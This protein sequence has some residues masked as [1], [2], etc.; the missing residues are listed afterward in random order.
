MRSRIVIL[1][2]ICSACG[3]AAT[4]QLSSWRPWY[5]V[6]GDQA[7]APQPGQ[8]IRIT[9]EGVTE[10]L[11]GDE[12]LFREQLQSRLADLLARRGYMLVSSGGEWD[13][14]LLYRTSAQAALMMNANT[15]YSS[16]SS[17]WV[18]GTMGSAWG[19][20]VA[21]ASALS[22]GLLSSSSSTSNLNVYQQNGFVHTIALEMRGDHGIETWKGEAR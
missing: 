22:A 19:Q 10:P 11:I 15:Y 16:R 4:P 13:C 18:R 1:A 9:V 14:K 12:T 17:S 7:R 3:C 21:F 20:G 8:S 2:L 5:R 6:I